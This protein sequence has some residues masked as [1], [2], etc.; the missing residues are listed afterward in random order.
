[1]GG[2]LVA[3]LEESS[4]AVP[5]GVLDCIIDQFTRYASVS[6]ARGRSTMC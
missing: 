4:S 1:M 3:L 2:I 6:R 5:T